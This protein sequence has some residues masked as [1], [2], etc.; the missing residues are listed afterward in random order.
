MKFLASHI[1]YKSSNSIWRLEFIEFTYNSMNNNN[2]FWLH[3]MNKTFSTFTIGIS[4]DFLNE[5]NFFEN[6]ILS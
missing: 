5:N 3:E 6:N 2:K 1:H 4:S